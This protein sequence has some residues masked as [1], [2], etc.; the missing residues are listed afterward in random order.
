ME[1]TKALEGFKGLPEDF[2]ATIKEGMK[3]MA[4]LTEKELSDCPQFLQNTFTI[5]K[6]A[7][8]EH[9]D[10]YMGKFQQ[11]MVGG[12]L[13]VLTLETVVFLFALRRGLQE[14]Y[15]SGYEQCMRDTF[16]EV[17]KEG[18]SL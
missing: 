8:V 9:R 6:K 10:S 5:H 12:P 11:I 16:L 1:K 14:G 2:Y 18:E 7:V 13:S 15:E 3:E 17:G 4:A